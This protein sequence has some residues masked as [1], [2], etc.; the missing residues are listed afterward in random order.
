ME[1]MSNNYKTPEIEYSLLMNKLEYIEFQLR[2]IFGED[3]KLLSKG[4]FKVLSYFFYYPNLDE[5]F[6]KILSSG[7]R[8]NRKSIQNDLTK[9]RDKSYNNLLT[10]ED[11]V[12]KF[13]ENIVILL[14]PAKFE[15]NIELHE[16]N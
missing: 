12:V 5:S 2:L 3:S 13:N 8:T 14:E 9:F 6:N 10:V 4:E 16:S 7:L 15:L 11:G 1:S